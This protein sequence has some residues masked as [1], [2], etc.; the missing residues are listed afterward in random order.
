MAELTGG[1][2][3]LKYS[4]FAFNVLFFLLGFILFVIAIVTLVRGEM[5]YHVFNINGYAAGCI[6]ISIII[7]VIGF[8]GCCGAIRESRCMLI[9]YIILLV[10][11]LLITLI[12]LI[13]IGAFMTWFNSNI[14]EEMFKSLQF[15]SHNNTG[16][17][18]MWNVLQSQAECCGVYSYTDWKN[19]SQ[20]VPDSCCKHNNTVK[21][22]DGCGKNLAVLPES[23]VKNKIYT[24]GCNEFVSTS[25]SMVLKGLLGVVSILFIIEIIGIIISCCLQ[26]GVADAESYNK[27]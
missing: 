3:C 5:T 12:V 14:D 27:M 8:F 6:V 17:R 20:S 10:I 7:M 2:K 18:T 15:Y 1:Q 13:V 19:V 9:T 21:I 26:R 25:L 4:M 24:V 22:F 16:F 11:I 23:A